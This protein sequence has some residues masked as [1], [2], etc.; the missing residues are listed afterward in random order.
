[1]NLENNSV[2]KKSSFGDKSTV[3]VNKQT[4]QNCFVY[5]FSNMQKSQQLQYES[6]PVS[7]LSANSANQKE[8][9][10]NTVN[11]RIK[12]TD[13]HTS[14]NNNTKSHSFTCQY[15]RESEKMLLV[16]TSKISHAYIGPETTTEEV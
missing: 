6:I 5:E 2:E 14:A 10:A 16:D 7:D 11:K 1:M 12:S 13:N 3:P 15:F 9:D 8:V 4:L